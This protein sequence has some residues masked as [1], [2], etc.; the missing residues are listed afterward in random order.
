MDAEKFNFKG[1]FCISNHNGLTEPNM[2]VQIYIFTKTKIY[3]V[4][5]IISIYIK[6]K[7]YIAEVSRKH[8]L[9]HAEV[10]FCHN[11]ES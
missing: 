8:S 11:P 3:V 4:E 5:C 7:I 1:L 10:L 9:P 2:R 6:S